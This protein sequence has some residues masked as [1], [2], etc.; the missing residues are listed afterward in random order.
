MKKPIFS[1]PLNNPF[2]MAQGIV[3]ALLVVGCQ[4]NSNKSNPG[5]DLSGTSTAA[6]TYTDTQTQTQTQV[7]VN[8]PP[9]ASPVGQVSSNGVA[10]FMANA[11]DNDQ[12]QLTYLWNFGDGKNSTLASPMHNYPQSEIET[13]Y[14]AQ[15]IITDSKGDSISKVVTVVVPA[16]P[17]VVENTI[18]TSNPTFNVGQNGSVS[19]AANAVDLDGDVLTYFWDFKDGTTLTTASPMHTYALTDAIQNFQVTLTVSDTDGNVI[20]STLNV[21][22]PAVLPPPNTAPIVSPSFEYGSQ[23]ND[24]LIVNFKAGATDA[25]NDPLTYNWDFKDGSFSDVANPS[26][27]YQMDFTEVT[28]NVQLMVSD[29]VNPAVTKTVSITVPSKPVVEPNLV[30]LL[31][32]ENTMGFCGFNGSV[33]GDHAGFSGAGYADGINEAGASIT[34]QIDASATDTYQLVFAFA[35]GGAATRIGTLDVNGQTQNVNFAATTNEWANWQ[36]QNASVQ[37]QAGVNT[38][39][40]TANT[41]D[42]L[43]NIDSLTVSLLIAG[44]AQ[45]NPANCD[46]VIYPVNNN[47]L[48]NGDLEQAVTLPWVKRGAATIN[49]VTSQSRTSSHS[50][51]VTGRTATWNGAGYK[52]DRLT[53]GNIYDFKVWV[54]LAAGEASANMKF[55]MQLTDD[56]GVS[57]HAISEAMANSD[58]WTLL[59]G[60]YDHQPAG[61]ATDLLV[62]VE[63]DSDTVS[64]FMDDLSMTGVI[65]QLATCELPSRFSWTSSGPLV[66]PQ[67]SNWASVKDPTIVQYNGKFHIW[68]TVF[69][70]DQDIWASAYINFSD[71]ASAGSSVQ[72]PMAGTAVGNSIAPQVFYF[73]PQDKWYLITQWGGA[74]ATT[75]DPT[76]INSWSSK[77]KLLQN[78][79]NGS[80]DFWVICDDD[81]CYLYFSRDDGVLYVSKTTVANFPNFSGYEIVME[82]HRGNGNSFLFEASNVYKVD[83]QDLYLLLVEAYRTPGYGPRYFRSWTATSLDGTWQALADTEENPF[84]GNNNVDWQGNKWAD[85]ISHGEMIRSG[86]NQKMTIDPCNLQYLYQGDTGAS[87]DGTYGGEPYNLGILNA[88]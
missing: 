65:E 87:I 47:L 64:F 42:G 17:A 55:T 66:K 77:R 84:A 45:I 24:E 12:D 28:H 48:E 18:P 16:K 32:E 41:A 79:P 72:V 1:K 50:L 8:T 2:K 7:G 34:W 29:G 5:E 46:A 25:E 57:Y 62:Y 61:R 83:G 27:S 9:V 82:D 20:P 33:M 38:I 6:N 75:N 63:S 43:P 26:H 37:M 23:A 14:N 52:I 56:N 3:F 4:E 85:G 35:N 53:S 30:T 81:N 49:V 69:D 13:Q 44:D 39:K 58:G 67:K 78:E 11:F 68:A 59:S 15:V 73:E 80:L 54:K 22:L 31:L 19:F 36:T 70:L 51:A 71:W 86:I 21:Q 60:S 88:K 74:Y 10:S 40:L 76:N